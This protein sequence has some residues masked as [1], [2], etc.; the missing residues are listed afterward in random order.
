MRFAHDDVKNAASG[1]R[2]HGHHRATILQHR[3]GL[4]SV[5]VRWHQQD[6]RVEEARC[7]DQR[8]FADAGTFPL[9]ARRFW[10]GPC[11]PV[12]IKGLRALFNHHSKKETQICASRRSP[13]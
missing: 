1:F 10:H 5:R 2:A 8:N 12:S 13:R 3:D 9:L 7:A 4:K 6:S 11:T